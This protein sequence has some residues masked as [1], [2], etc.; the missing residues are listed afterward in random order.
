VLLKSVL[1]AVRGQL[2]E[3]GKLERRATVAEV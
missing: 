3:W 1:Y 2:V